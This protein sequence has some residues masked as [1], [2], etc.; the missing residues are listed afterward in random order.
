MLNRVSH[1]TIKMNGARRAEIQ[2]DERHATDGDPI[3][4]ANAD[5]TDPKEVLLPTYEG[6]HQHFPTWSTDGRWIYVS[7]GVIRTDKMD[8][9]RFRPDGTGLKQL[10]DGLRNV[11][12]PAPVDERT[13]LFIAGD[14]DGSGPWLWELDVETLDVRRA[15]G[16]TERYTSVSAS[17]SGHRLVVTGVDPRVDLWTVPILQDREATEA[18]VRAHPLPSVRAFAPRSSHQGTTG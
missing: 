1:A 13:V 9:W 5:G 7:R 10:T 17:R 4:I 18:D 15:H 3:F 14:T 6:Y 11:S 8:L 2:P 12:Y 16:G